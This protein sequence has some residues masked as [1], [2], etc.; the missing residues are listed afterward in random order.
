MLT[1]ALSLVMLSTP[2]RADAFAFIFAGETN[3]ID[4]VTHP[5]GYT[6]SGGTLDISVGIDPTSTNSAAMQTPV[7]NIVNTWNSLIG[8][9]DNLKFASNN[10]IPTG[11]YDFESTALHELG[12]SLGLAHVNAASES[13]LTGSDR[14]YT[15]A[16]DGAN[17]VFEIDDG[18]DNIIGSRDDIRGDDVNLNWF[19]KS[20]NNPFGIDSVVDSTTYSR[21]LADL[22]VGDNFS[23]NP[24]RNVATTY[25]LTLNSLVG[26]EAVMQQGTFFDEDQRTFG[27]DDAAGLLYGMSGLDEIAGTLD[28]YI[29]NLTFSGLDAGADIVL[30]FDN[31]QTSF[32][33][34]Q[35]SGAFINA[36]HLRIT[37]TSIFFNTSLNWF[38]NDESN[39][40]P[41]PEPTTIALLGIGLAGLGGRYLRRKHKKDNQ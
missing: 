19:R 20:N 39:S 30:D 31:A 3:G 27:H 6:G 22:P 29:F 34:S 35:F 38:F 41:I 25:G 5:L 36:D 24:D 12:H 9:I 17:N 26:T 21:D 14:N 16:T 18:T 33:I 13:G 37:S 23:A 10:N 8:T 40:A 4:V 7:Q 15:K 2:Q 11:T 1:V 28:D 32:A